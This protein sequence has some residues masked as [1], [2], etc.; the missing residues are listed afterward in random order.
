MDG[1]AHTPTQSSPARPRVRVVSDRAPNDPRSPAPGAAKSY[2]QGRGVVFEIRPIRAADAELIVAAL[3]YTSDETY[4]RRFHTAKRSFSSKELRY[5]TEI[6]GQEHVALVA[7]ERSNE[8]RL[9]AVARFCADPNNWLEA[10][11]AICVHDP[12]RRQGLG[13]ELLR[14]L[15]DEASA[16][17]LIQLRAMVQSDNIAMRKLLYHVFPDT[18]IDGISG[19]EVDYLVPVQP[20]IAAATAA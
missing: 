8:Q 16:R 15:H 11:L 6:D 2:Y 18:T 10:D 5:L 19:Y 14:R 3:S 13:A 1:S 7:I 20:S 9:A 4:Y 17:S 12:F